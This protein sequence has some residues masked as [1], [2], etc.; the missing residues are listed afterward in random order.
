MVHSWFI[1]NEMIYIAFPI[2]FE[3]DGDI[4]LLI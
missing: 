1:S 3:I 4:L 2:P